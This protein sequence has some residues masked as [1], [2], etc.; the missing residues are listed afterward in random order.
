[1]LSS[2]ISSMILI[3]SLNLNEWENILYF[4]T[5]WRSLNWSKIFV[6]ICFNKTY[7]IFLHF[8]FRFC[9]YSTYCLNI[10]KIPFPPLGFSPFPCLQLFLHFSPLWN[11]ARCKFGTHR[12]EECTRIV[13]VLK[14]V[15]KIE[16][17]ISFCVFL[18]Y[19]GADVILW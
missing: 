2:K 17:L 4:W 3:F 16:H 6:W 1:M 15:I 12:P 14:S 10:L 5:W 9:L 18:F 19:M 7:F 8:G 13:I 11:R